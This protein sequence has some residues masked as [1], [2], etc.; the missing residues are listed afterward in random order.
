MEDPG[1]IPGGGVVVCLFASASAQSVSEHIS[2]GRLIPLTCNCPCKSVQ[3]KLCLFFFVPSGDH[4][5]IA[6]MAHCTVLQDDLRLAARS[7]CQSGLSK[8]HFARTCW[9]HALLR[10]VC[11]SLGACDLLRTTAA[12]LSGVDCTLCIK[13]LTLCP[14]G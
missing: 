3:C 10:D 7:G 4:I 1:S 14:S 9:Q 2:S 13:P 8:Y 12:P 11:S 6:G 5:D